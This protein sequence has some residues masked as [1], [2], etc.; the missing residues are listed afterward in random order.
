MSDNA[1]NI[2]VINGLKGDTELRL[3]R[4]LAEEER[5]ETDTLDGWAGRLQPGWLVFNSFTT[6][7]LSRLPLVRADGRIL[8]L[9]RGE[10]RLYADG[11]WHSWSA[12]DIMKVSSNPLEQP[13]PDEFP[14]TTRAFFSPGG[15]VV[16]HP[17]VAMPRVL[18]NG[19]WIVPT[20]YD[21]M[22]QYAGSPPAMEGGPLSGQEGRKR[23]TLKDSLMLREGKVRRILNGEWREVFGGR[24]IPTLGINPR[25]EL[26]PVLCAGDY[27]VFF[28]GKSV[29]VV[30]EPPYPAPEAVAEIV[31]GNHIMLSVSNQPGNAPLHWR[32]SDKWQSAEETGLV[33]G[34]LPNGKHT[35]WCRFVDEGLRSGPVT[36]LNVE[37]VTNADS[38]EQWLLAV[39]DP[40]SGGA[41]AAQASLMAMGREALPHLAAAGAA[42]PP[43]QALRLRRLAL[44]IDADFITA[45]YSPLVERLPEPPTSART[46]AAAVSA[47]PLQR[48]SAGY[49][50]RAY[51]NGE[52]KVDLMVWTGARWATVCPGLECGLYGFAMAFD[53]IGRIWVSS[54]NRESQAIVGEPLTDNRFGDRAW[55]KYFSLQDALDA[56]LTADTVFAPGPLLPG[57][58][59][60]TNRRAWGLHGLLRMQ[61]GGLAYHEDNRVAARLGGAWKEWSLAEVLGI[62]GSEQRAAAWRL[63]G[64]GMPEIGTNEAS[65]RLVATASPVKWDAAGQ[66][67][68]PEDECFCT[69]TREL[70]PAPP[71]TPPLVNADLLEKKIQAR[72]ALGDGTAWHYGAQGLFREGYG[73]RR[74]IATADKLPVVVGVYGPEDIVQSPCG[75]VFISALR[76]RTATW[77]FHGAMGMELHDIPPDTAAALEGNG[78]GTLTLRFNPPPGTRPFHTWRVDGG[79]WLCATDKPEATLGPLAPGTHWVEVRAV[80]EWVVPDPEP[81]VLKGD[82]VLAPEL[83][84]QWLDA[85]IG[86]N[87]AAR[88]RAARS[89]VVLGGEMLPRLEA[90][91]ERAPDNDARWWVDT[92]IQQINR[93][94]ANQSETGAVDGENRSVTGG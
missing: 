84:G 88:E 75:M 64:E 68:M 71:D 27:P 23:A 44:R 26:E 56:R 43:D 10:L 3:S 53:S 16:L 35:V 12:K 47:A 60:N 51:N 21:P 42:A 80:T 18:K 25:A 59:Q 82:V 14:Q 67:L 70:C 85:L 11:K 39:A 4:F 79:P 29:L 87:P 33:I 36:G 74:L 63:N 69:E 28:T 89:L 66:A 20:P 77:D 58:F 48:D 90:L 19:Q 37:I 17:S 49:V 41:E 2:W 9:A 57:S 93:S 24:V 72:I 30:L 65:A 34:P 38:M 22:L 86:G 92:V 1:G 55:K 78:D 73:L 6:Q 45:P 76:Q 83:V 62:P 15:E 40:S 31:D 46:P 5:F 61:D 50:W 54:K 91:R 81:L 52:N 13:P 7:I 32:M 8:Q 94:M